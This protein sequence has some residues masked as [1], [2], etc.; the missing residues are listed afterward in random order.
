M[1][2]TAEQQALVLEHHE[3][4][5]KMGCVLWRKWQWRV[6]PVMDWEDAAHCGVVG[7]LLAAKK[8]DEQKG[9]FRTY[10]RYRIRQ[11]VNNAVACVLTNRSRSYF[12]TRPTIP[13]A[14]R[15]LT[16]EGDV[17]CVNGTFFTPMA[18][19]VPF[20]SD[21]C[22]RLNYIRKLTPRQLYV[23]YATVV[24]EHTVRDVAAALAISYQAVHQIQERAIASAQIPGTRLRGK[25]KPK[26][27]KLTFLAAWRA[28]PL[29]AAE[30]A[31]QH[32]ISVSTACRWTREERHEHRKQTK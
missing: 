26:A 18:L 19:S 6:K 27:Q 15:Y 20:Q 22:W 12:H 14:P 23:L 28:S 21:Y 10:A 30:L 24:Y 17:L 16:S 9:S 1:S 2:L 13:H 32:G 5:R 29:T 3:W 8:Y 11:E 31:E 25:A 7:L 4:A